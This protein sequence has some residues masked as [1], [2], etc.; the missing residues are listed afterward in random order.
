MERVIEPVILFAAIIPLARLYATKGFR[1]RLG[2][3]SWFHVLI[4]LSLFGYLAFIVVLFIF[5]PILLRV[6]VI[7]ALATYLCLLWFAHPKYGN[8]HGLPPGSL[9]PLPVGQWNDP[10]YYEKK[11][12][13]YGPIFKACDLHRPSV[14]LLGIEQT[15]KLLSEHADALSTPAASYNRFIPNGFLRFTQ[16]ALHQK[17]RPVFANV[18]APELIRAT[19]PFMCEMMNQEFARMA[20]ASAENPRGIHPQE[21]LERMVRLV[22]F[23]LFFSIA[24]DSERFQHCEKL[25]AVIAPQNLARVSDARVQHT[26]AEIVALVQKTLRENPQRRSSVS[27]LIRQEP[28]AL[29]SP[30]LMFNLIYMLQVGH[31]DVSALLQW[32]LKMLA[33]HPAWFARLQAA[34]AASDLPRRVVSETLRLEQSEFLLRQTKHDLHLQGCHIPKGWFVRACIKESHRASAAFA[35]ANDFDPDRFLEHRFTR[36]E[37]MPFGAFQKSCL[38]EYL[39][40]SIGTIFVRE[41]ARNFELQLLHDGAPEFGGFHWQPSSKFRVSLKQLAL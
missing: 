1:R 22:F 41:L 13:Q 17:Y 3:L 23:S 21:Y 28:D 10:R 6:A 25:F 12:R 14:C 32:V 11:F 4:P 38:G 8:A 40:M 9:F 33:A 18:F 27:E 16:P 31:G 26:L 37:Y 19:E 7:F 30:F 36:A 2:S 39:T 34:G 35:Q 20:Q 24:P 5:F 29:R 15:H